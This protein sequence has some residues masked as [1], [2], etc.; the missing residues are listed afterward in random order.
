MSWLT[1]AAMKAFLEW[2]FGK[3]QAAYSLWKKDKEN[4]D[5][6]IAQAAK[7]SKKAKE[8]QK[9]PNASEKETDDAI[10]DQFNRL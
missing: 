8:V 6:E 3:L 9:N 10:D 4:H 1:S 5:K 2:L 7:D